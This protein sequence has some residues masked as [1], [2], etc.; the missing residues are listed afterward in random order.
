MIALLAI[1]LL[2]KNWQC[3][4]PDHSKDAEFVQQLQSVRDSAAI[5]AQLADII[6]RKDSALLQASIDTF[7]TQLATARRLLNSSQRKTADLAAGVV[8]SKRNKD[9]TGYIGNCDSLADEIAGLN[10][11]INQYVD[12][13]DSL[14]HAYD[15]L[16]VNTATRLAGFK[17]LYVDEHNA[18]LAVE[19]QF[20]K[21]YLDYQ[22]ASRKAGR[23]WGVGLGAGIGIMTDGKVGA[24]IGITVSR[25]L[26]RF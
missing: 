8:I 17:K 26:F 13:S 21:L 14:T 24:A 20:Q 5:A 2:T 4:A 3:K 15:S 11:L 9:T 18:F 25:T 23:K 16:Q 6:K 12:Y 1:L 10:W 7:K 22:K 19:G